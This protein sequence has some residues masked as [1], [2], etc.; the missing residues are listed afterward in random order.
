VHVTVGDRDQ[1]GGDAFPRDVNRVG[2]RARVAA[3]GVDGEGNLL[4]L[5]GGAEQVEDDG[6][7]QRAS[8]QY[9]A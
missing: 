9:G 8:R 2:V 7:D 1:R 6:V 5:G 3:G 4:L